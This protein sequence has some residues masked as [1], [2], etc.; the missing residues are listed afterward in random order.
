MW[1]K[2]Y[3]INWIRLKDCLGEDCLFPTRSAINNEVN[4]EHNESYKNIIDYGDG[5]SS[6]DDSET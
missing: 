4:N 2:L 6:K 5:I 3:R 1:S